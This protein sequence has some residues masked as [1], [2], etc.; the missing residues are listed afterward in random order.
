MIIAS[1]LS[2]DKNYDNIPKI[3]EH[4]TE[5]LENAIDRMTEQIKAS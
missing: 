1:Q 4:D 5:Y 3:N 2:N